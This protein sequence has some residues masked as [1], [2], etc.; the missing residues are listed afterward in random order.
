MDPVMPEMFVVAA[1]K[2]YPAGIDT[3]SWLPVTFVYAVVVV[4]HST[5]DDPKYPGTDLDV[6]I[7]EAT[8][9]DPGSSVAGRDRSVL[10]PSWLGMM[11]MRAIAAAS[12]TMMGRFMLMTSA[13]DAS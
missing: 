11:K 7:D 1:T 2:V 10:V 9:M 12:A 8:G 6:G 4:V 13:L 3:G 5:I